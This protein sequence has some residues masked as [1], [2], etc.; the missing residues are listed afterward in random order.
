VLGELALGTAALYAA[1]TL[2]GRL[3]PDL[4]HGPYPSPQEA[5][6]EID[7]LA[8]RHP[9]RARIETIGLSREGRPIRALR[10]CASRE[11]RARLLVTAHIHAVEYIGGFAARAVARLLADGYGRD[12]VASLLLD[13]AEVCLV[14]L[15]NPD[16]AERVWRR[17]G[18][19]GLGW[20]RFTAAGVDPNRNFPFREA[21]G[22]RAWNSGR[23]RPGSAYYRG[24][25]PLS[26]PECLALARL[27]KRER[28]CAAVNFHSFGGVIYLPEPLG[29]DREKVR[30]ALEVFQGR[31]QEHQPGLRY[32]P[33]P[34]R[35]SA[36]SGQLDAFL[37]YGFGTP[38]VTVEVSRP[39]LHL[40]AP[41]R[42]FN[43]FWLA[44]PPY[45]ERDAR[46]VAAATLH[47]LAELLER[48]GGE[49]FRPALPELA[50]RVPD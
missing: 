50:R 22:L 13:R 45:P 29:E 10:L 20:S 28:F 32:R 30:R 7:T 25:H 37:L 1:G 24:P 5:E 3:H 49:P 33:V 18:W 16:G 9:E 27:A 21:T 46:N 38:S 31:F 40:L 14:P 36:I 11:P 17:G 19:S 2:Y 47:A 39:G 34:E 42:T 26:E 48:T 35:A 43:L 44:N 8:E 15:L 6:R 4:A 23:E 12:P 41:W